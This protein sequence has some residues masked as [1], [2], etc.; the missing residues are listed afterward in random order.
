MIWLLLL[1][2][3]GLVVPMA[4]SGKARAHGHQRVKAEVKRHGSGEV[5]TLAAA[6]GDA[7][8]SKRR[9]H[10]WSGLT[11]QAVLLTSRL[12]RRA[13]DGSLAV[14]E[15]NIFPIIVWFVSQ[16]INSTIFS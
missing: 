12:H 8:H 3:N 10:V 5:G 14:N 1:L 16:T 6:T 11:A 7:D 4:I 9:T 2:A 13:R 15:H